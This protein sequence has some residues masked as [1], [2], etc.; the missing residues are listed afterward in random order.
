[1]RKTTAWVRADKLRD[2]RDFSNRFRGSMR[3][4]VRGNLSPLQMG[5]V[6][7]IASGGILARLLMES[8][9]G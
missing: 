6:E 9:E 4:L 5:E 8:I 2:G 7:V 1:M 3:E